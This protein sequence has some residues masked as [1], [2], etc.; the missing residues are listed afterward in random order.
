MDVP[1]VPPARPANTDRFTAD[2]T[3]GLNPRPGCTLDASRLEV[4]PDTCPANPL[5][6]GNGPDRQV[7]LRVERND[8][9][10]S[11][12]IYMPHMLTLLSTVIRRV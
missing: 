4:L 9:L 5:D 2:A 6:F 3:D 8:S 11:G 12:L 1:G 10:A 7:L